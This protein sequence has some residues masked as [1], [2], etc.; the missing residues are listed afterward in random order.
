MNGIKVLILNILLKSVFVVCVT[1]AAIHFNN[2]NILWWYT[3]ALLL[4]YNY[5]SKREVTK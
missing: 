4:G 1:A 3:F 2:P 5:E